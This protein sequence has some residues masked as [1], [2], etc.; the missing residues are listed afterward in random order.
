[1]SRFSVLPHVVWEGV[2]LVF[3]LVATAL[4]VAQGHLFHGSGPWPQLAVYGTLAAGLALSLRTRTPN[5]AVASIAS[6]SGVVY[7]VLLHADWPLGL[8][9]AV[10]VLTA[11]GFGLVLAVIVGLTG[12]PAWA[13]SLGG[14]ALASTIGLANGV[15]LRP[16]LDGAISPEWLTAFAALFVV[17][18]LAGGALWLVPA[19]GSGLRA[20]AIEGEPAPG[21][22]RRLLAALVGL[23]GSSLLAGLAGV[24]E[25][26]RLTSVVFTSSQG[27]LLFALGAVLLGGVSLTGRGGGIAGTVLAAYLLVT[28]QFLLIYDGDPGWAAKFLPLTVAILLGVLVSRLLDRFAARSGPPSAT[29]APT[30]YLP[31]GY[32]HLAYPLAGYPHPGYPDAG[33]VPA[34]PAAPAP[35]PVQPTVP[36]APVT[37][38][39]PASEPPPGG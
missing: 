14:V 20:T 15:T 38:A 18:S 6:L 22:G 11:L 31:G 7:A 28:V 19:V 12:A 1:V 25:A 17:G 23:G 5:L 32:P 35:S 34:Q 3:A 33:V 37:P 8:A 2:L 26:G 29:P 13:V 4:S 16:I 39:P 27:D 24:L 9:A 30:P 21:I 10:A 36:A